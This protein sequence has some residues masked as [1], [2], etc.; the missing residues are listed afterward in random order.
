MKLETGN[1]KLENIMK[2]LLFPVLVTVYGSLLTC[3]PAAETGTGTNVVKSIVVQQAITL[4]GE[5]RTTWPSGTSSTNVDVGGYGVTNA[6][7]IALLTQTN[8]PTQGSQ[9]AVILYCRMVDAPFDTNSLLLL[10]MNGTNG[11]V[12]FTDSSRSNYPVTVFG[13]ARMD[14]NRSVYG[15]S[16]AIFD[17]SSDYLTI[18]N[19]G[20]FNPGSSDFT[21]EFYARVS[22]N[23]AAFFSKGYSG[24]F[25]CYFQSLGVRFQVGGLEVVAS[26]DV[27][28]SV[29]WRHYACVKTGV[30]G[31]IFIDGVKAAESSV[32]AS[33]PSNDYDFCVGRR[34]Q[35]GD[36]DFSGHIDELRF[37][38]RAVYTTNF[39]PPAEFRPS[40][41][42]SLIARFGTNEVTI[43]TG[44][45]Q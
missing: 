23:A 18:P 29:Y 28:S 16:S 14:T 12:S 34:L 41:V 39:T 13:N 33:V 10:G 3:S 36:M 40:T 5:T 31:R 9:G 17:G 19:C 6:S 21:V 45:A 22:N 8:L 35:W 37:S 42:P 43:A 27:T 24:G 20:A 30:V 38:A 32:V 4:G 15:G 44:G 26:T 11:S 7:Y 1:S 2:R 25:A